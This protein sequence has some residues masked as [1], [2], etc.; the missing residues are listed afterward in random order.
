M[1]DYQESQ[2]GIDSAQVLENAAYKQAMVL[3]RESIIDKWKA[4]PIRDQE[5][6]T[7][8]LQTMRLA[9]TFEEVLRG[10][11]ERG[12]FAQHRIDIDNQRNE[13]GARKM[14]RRVL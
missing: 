1:S 10:M 4:C 13:S 11:I 2:Q 8:L 5:G 14:M 12:K 9:D 3:M 6:Q 7:L